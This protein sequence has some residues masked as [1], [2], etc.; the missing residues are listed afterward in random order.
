MNMIADVGEI[1]LKTADAT[2][3]VPTINKKRN[4]LSFFDGKS[5]VYL[6]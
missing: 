4:K 1:I 5:V 6:I 3:H 2:E